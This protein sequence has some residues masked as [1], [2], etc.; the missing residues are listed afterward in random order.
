MV[1]LKELTKTYNKGSL[2]AVDKVS[3][4]VS[5]GELFGLIGPDGAGKTSI[6][7]MLTT[8]LLP[9]GGSATVDGFDIVK[10]Y[11]QIR[12]TVGY[13]P[14]RF[15]LYQD[16]TVEENLKFFATVFNTT[17]EENYHLIKDIYIQI[18]PFKTRRAGKLSGGM[19]QK[20]ALCCALVHK[21]TVLFLDEPTT[22]VDAVSRKEFWEML[23]KLKEQGITILV[24][25]PYMD[26]AT[27]CDRIALIQSGKILSID[28]PEQI[29]GSYKGNLY[30]I[31]SN[32][33][34][35]LLKDVHQYAETL[36]CYAFGEYLH[37]QF[38]NNNTENETLLIN[39]LK[40][41]DHRNL[42]LKQTIPTIE[43]CFIKL[44]TS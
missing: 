12:N 21:P 14:G 2:T 43:D 40:Q 9:D 15:S 26:E 27:L 18:E 3:F 13:M 39:Y 35:Q 8:L 19:K 4:E 36:S 24:S 16:L 5:K 25:T 31:K 37:I 23:K 7:R 34:Y 41:K 32:K 6:F 17:I 29:I 42:T 28:T 11:K 44:M 1:N 20:L 38:K 10:D 22:G 30:A 33:I